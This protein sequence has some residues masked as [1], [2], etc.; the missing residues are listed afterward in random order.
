MQTLNSCSSTP[1]SKFEVKFETLTKLKKNLES[2]S[3]KCT[4]IAGMKPSNMSE[5]HVIKGDGVR[6]V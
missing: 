6:S 1:G 3:F 5:T 2:T 4:G